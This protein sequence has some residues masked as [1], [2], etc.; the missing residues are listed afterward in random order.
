MSLSILRSLAQDH[1]GNRIGTQ[2]MSHSPKHSSS[3]YDTSHSP[4]TFLDYFHDFNDHFQ[5]CM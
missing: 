3:D 4:T 2:H 5:D 1:I